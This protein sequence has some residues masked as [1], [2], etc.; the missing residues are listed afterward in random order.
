MTDFDL[1]DYAKYG[2][3]AAAN[4][5]Q[6]RSED[7]ADMAYEFGELTDYLKRVS[8]ITETASKEISNGNFWVGPTADRYSEEFKKCSNE[9]NIL[10]RNLE[11]TNLCLMT[12]S[13]NIEY[14]NQQLIDKLLKDL[15]LRI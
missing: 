8:V 11:K 3:I 5:V 1:K 6:V 10:I 15:D 7:F 13:G 4:Y 9:L 2:S 14:T 12:L